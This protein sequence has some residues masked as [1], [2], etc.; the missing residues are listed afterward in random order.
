MLSLDLSSEFVKTRQN[1]GKYFIALEYWVQQSP[2]QSVI[3]TIS[4]VA[5]STSAARIMDWFASAQ[6]QYGCCSVVIIRYM[7]IFRSI[8]VSVSTFYPAEIRKLVYD[9]PLS[10]FGMGE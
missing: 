3:F 5:Q 2:F 8:T 4:F 10:L 9:K 1:S 6:L 7:L